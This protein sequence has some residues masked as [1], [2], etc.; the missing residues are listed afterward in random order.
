MKEGKGHSPECL[1]GTLLINIF[2]KTIVML[3]DQVVERAH[4]KF[5]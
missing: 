5:Y 1:K 4:G 2:Y 3:L